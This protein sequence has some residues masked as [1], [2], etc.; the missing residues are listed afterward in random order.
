M[1]V[2]NRAMYELIVYLHI[3]GAILSIGPFFVLFPLLKRMEREKNSDTLKGHV[4]SFHLAIQVVKHAGHFLI[5]F[6]L[7]AMWRG[8]YPW[9]TPWIVCTFI[10]LMSSVVYLANAFKP[11]IRTF[12][13]PQFNQRI[14]VK[15]LR[16][17]V[18]IYVILLLIMLWLMVAKPMFW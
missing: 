4:D 7:L 1:K 16:R 17:A 9:N 14:F 5:I 11:T 18:Y 13:T 6:G 10:L 3:L 8:H 15:K 2:G 12:N